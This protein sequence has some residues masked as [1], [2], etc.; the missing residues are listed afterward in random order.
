MSKSS[1][2]EFTEVSTLAKIE[3]SCWVAMLLKN[4]HNK[5]RDA[6]KH[7]KNLAVRILSISLIGRNMKLRWQSATMA[8]DPPL[9]KNFTCETKYTCENRVLTCYYVFLTCYNIEWTFKS[10]SSNE[11]HTNIF[12]AINP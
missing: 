3:L 1:R 7:F 6:V 9:L 10:P 4:K 8:T 5:F 12:E 2:A 11:I